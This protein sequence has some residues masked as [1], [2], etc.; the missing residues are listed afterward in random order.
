MLD[1]VRHERNCINDIGK[2][3]REHSIFN[4]QVSKKPVML[5]IIL[6]PPKINNENN[7]PAE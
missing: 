6:L 7:P 4:K 3:D 1:R 2:T 5:Q